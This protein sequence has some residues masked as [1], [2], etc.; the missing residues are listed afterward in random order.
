M[1]LQGQNLP[2]S[3]TATQANIIQVFNPLIYP[4]RAIDG[5]TT[6]YNDTTSISEAWLE[7][8]LGS[9]ETIG[10]IKSGTGKTVARIDLISSYILVSEVP[11]MTNH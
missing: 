1:Q 2:L 11:L 10:T 7:V 3:A 6:T 5:D 4:E 9:V 8:D